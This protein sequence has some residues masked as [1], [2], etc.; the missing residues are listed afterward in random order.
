MTLV[1]FKPQGEEAARLVPLFVAHGDV[2]DPQDVSEYVIDT[3]EKL[4]V[5]LNL[6]TKKAMTQFLRKHGMRVSGRRDAVG[7]FNTIV[8]SWDEIVR[9]VGSRVPSVPT[10]TSEGSGSSDPDSAPSAKASGVVST[11]PDPTPINLNMFFLT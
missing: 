1:F 8:S 7:V 5:K 3:P 2:I 4:R 11:D 6:M 9:T 10:P